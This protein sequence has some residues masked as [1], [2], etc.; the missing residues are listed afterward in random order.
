MITSGRIYYTIYL[1]RM[2]IKN[3]KTIFTRKLASIILL[4]YFLFILLLQLSVHMKEFSRPFRK[5]FMYT[6]YY[7]SQWFDPESKYG[8]GDDGLYQVAGHTLAT[9]QE[10]FTINPEMP[11]LGKYMYGYSIVF[12]GNAEKAALIVFLLSIFFYYLIIKQFIKK[13]VL[14]V[15]S[16]IFFVTDPLIFGQSFITTLDLPQMLFMLTHILSFL[17]LLNKNIP[18]KK[19]LLFI[20][21]A[22]ITL[23]LFI[24]VK[25]AF[26]A[27]IIIFI[28]VLLLL[29]KRRLWQVLPIGI[30]ALLVYAS[31]YFMY[32][33]Q[34]HSFL[35]FLKNQKW[36]LHFYL[37][38]NIQ[39]V[40]GTVLSA[41]S[42]GKIIGWNDSSTWSQIAEWTIMWPVY[43]SL[44]FT[45]VVQC[46]L[47]RTKLN[48]NEMYLLFLTSGLFLAYCFLPFFTR[49]LVL[50][51]PLFIYFSIRFFDNARFHP[52]TKYVSILVLFSIHYYL[53]WHS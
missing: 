51:I 8:I 37:S 7:H 44:Y 49:Y 26:L 25:I 9:K 22:G 24:S 1:N 15:L 36:M 46:I 11:V 23:G 5:D 3:L 21:L 35:E 2:E 28:D 6:L 31:T 29:Q 20:G 14:Q 40:Y 48:E 50:L 30:L 13:L 27:V 42:I 4:V 18:P 19:Q 38:S 53:Y 43:L 33:V 52:W 17:P 16:L 39:P 47:K 45:T 32:F 34:G 12:L 41:L 10:F